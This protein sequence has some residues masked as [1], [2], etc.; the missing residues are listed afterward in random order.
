M[1]LYDCWAGLGFLWNPISAMEDSSSR[2][3]GPYIEPGG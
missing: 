3:M 1:S 2:R